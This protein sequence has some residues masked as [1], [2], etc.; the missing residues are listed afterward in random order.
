MHSISSRL[1]LAFVSV[2]FLMAIQGAVATYT[3]Q[4]ISEVQQTTKRAELAS[5][6][7]QNQLINNRLLIYRLVASSNPTEMDTLRDAHIQGTKAIKER[8][9]QTG[10]PTE[11]FAALE[12][13]YNEIILL[14]YDFFTNL[15]R[16]QLNTHSLEQYFT[17]DN[18]LE[19]HV[20]QL[21]HQSEKQVIQA[22]ATASRLTYGLGFAALLVAFI[23]AGI[24]RRTLTDRKL[25]DSA[26]EQLRSDLQDIINSMPSVL[27]AIDE[28]CTITQWNAQAAEHKG[29]DFSEL[30]SLNIFSAF[31]IIQHEEQLIR[32]TLDEGSIG[33]RSRILDASG[34]TTR[35][36]DITVYPLNSGETRRAVIRM[37]NV[38]ERTRLEDMMVQ[39]EKMMSVGGLA[40]GMAHEIRNPLAGIMHNTQNIIRRLSLN[41]P[42][43]TAVAQSL[44]LS[45]E[46]LQ[47]Y[48][49]QRKI[50][51]MLKG[52][53]DCGHR[54]S[55][56]VDNMLT[57]S[58][59]SDTEYAPHNLEHILDQ[60]IELAS[61]DYSLKQHFDFRTITITRNYS[62]AVP[63]VPCES[64]PVQQVL[65]NI[66][67]N[68]AH[69]MHEAGLRPPQFT[70]SLTREP[71]FAC[72]TI[73]DNGPGMP[74]SIRRRIFE[75]FFT[76][77]EVGEGTGLGLSVSYF[78]IVDQHE[79]RLN[80]DSVQGEGATFTLCLPLTGKKDS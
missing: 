51:H 70:V 36:W 24:L 44:Q 61:K 72:I 74:E 17:V 9:R 55:E 31:P 39:T 57:F 76:T 66:F 58:R 2:I 35:L 29:C 27:V 48:L 6:E 19:K 42:K 41:S 43:D 78:I 60:S 59:K 13:S 56:I 30:P 5:K 54:A 10:L 20:T 8:L 75:P 15:A 26:M 65:L 47:D 25:A 68:G 7:L 80:V 49:T 11:E 21:A 22:R 1:L 46:S 34:Q 73:Q 79:G 63:L 16:N 64:G 14:H 32:S 69:A 71:N 28:Q 38:T 62:P 53:Q 52:I 12:A 3:A 4:K 77:K 18:A 23:W 67:K 45:G 40:A 33:R 37:D 50:M